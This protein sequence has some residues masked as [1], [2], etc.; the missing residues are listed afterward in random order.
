M[1]IGGP[2][3][4]LDLLLRRV[5]LSVADV[6]G[7][8]ALEEHGLLAHK[9]QLLAQPLDVERLDVDIV[10]QDHAALRVV[11][12]LDELDDRGLTAARRA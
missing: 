2:G 4:L 3:G 7:D 8:R 5:W 11:E 10:K 1:G 9:A 6:I 12:A